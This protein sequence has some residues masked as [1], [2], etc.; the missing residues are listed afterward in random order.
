MDSKIAIKRS[1]ANGLPPDM[2]AARFPYNRPERISSPS[3]IARERNKRRGGEGVL[4]S[5]CLKLQLESSYSLS[6]ISYLYELH[7]LDHLL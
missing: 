1:K 7:P 6:W 3:H 2:K 4:F 5:F